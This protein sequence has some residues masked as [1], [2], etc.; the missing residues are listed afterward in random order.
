MVIKKIQLVLLASL[1]FL[2]ACGG[3]AAKN[4]EK[5]RI[6]LSESLEQ[7]YVKDLVLWAEAS[8]DNG[9]VSYSW[10]DEAGNILGDKALLIISAPIEL[11]TRDYSVIVTD[12]AHQ[13][14]TKKIRVTIINNKPTIVLPTTI[15]QVSNMDVVLSADVEDDGSVLNYVWEDSSGNVLG[16]KAVL[17]L[18]APHQLGNET[19]TLSVTDDAN[20]TSSESVIVTIRDGKY[21][22]EDHGLSIYIQNKPSSQY[23][24][25]QLS[26]AGFNSLSKENQ[27]KV[28][29]KLLS[30][31]FFAYPHNELKQRIESGHFISD[32]QQQFLV[33]ENDM[34]AVE[35]KIQDQNRYYQS[36]NRPDLK[37]L[38]RF[39]EMSKLDKNYLD[40]WTS[41]ILAQTILFSPAAELSSVANPDAFGVYNRL[42]TLQ[43]SEAG[44]RYVAFIHMQSDENWRRFRSPEDNGREMLEIYAL[45]ENDED[46]PIAAQALQNWHLNRDKDTLVI[47][48]NKN[49]EAL[50]LL[51]DMQF[52]TGVEFY[53]ALAKSN[54]FTKGITA[55]LVDFLFA[56]TNDAK[57]DELIDSI[58]SSN[59]ET[60]H[61]ILLQ[62]LFSED[63]LLRSSRV[64]SIEEVNF[65]LM[66]RFSYNSYYYSFS[67]LSNDMKRM[68][69][70]SMSYKLG[71][72]NRVPLDN[73]SFGTYQKYV[74][75]HIFRTWSRDTKLS[76]NKDRVDATNSSAY[77]MSNFKSYQRRGISSKNFM[78]ANKYEVVPDDKAK[79]VRN[80]I[81]YLFNAVLY[82]DIRADELQMF[83]NFI[84]GVSGASP[85]WFYNSLNYEN[86]NKDYQEYVRYSGRYSI[87]YLVFEY[88]LRLDELY[89]FKGVE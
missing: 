66:K 35:E 57:K 29:D 23:Q 67:N 84:E 8:D 56:N 51:D 78:S 21:S 64:K 20:Q 71:K 10:K 58:V 36:E 27:Y 38:S 48:L 28:A 88:M 59:P 52:T 75:D 17:V 85:Q 33:S 80:Y 62:I 40:H 76:W 13:T 61:D 4:D 72:S 44:M 50:T 79:T 63:Y 34:D 41:Y 32:I 42:Y 15:E 39:Y 12:D 3:N 43:E 87:Q 7:S 1:M 37:I 46:V 9:I 5:P 73:I 60:W 24:L 70:L 68:G 14:S 18:F 69:Q 49:T 6:T 81:K 55:R 83:M 74:K 30:T 45:D 65:S 11:G 16:D 86:D 77:F 2:V 25:Q 31:L 47:G 26:D 19:Y 89:F 82:R 53:A 54:A 22:S